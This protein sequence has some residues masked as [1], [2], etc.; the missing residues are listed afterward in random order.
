VWCGH[1]PQPLTH[2][3]C[4]GD[5]LVLAHLGRF[6]HAGCQ[7]KPE[8]AQQ[9]GQDGTDLHDAQGLVTHN[10]QS[11]RGVKTSETTNDNEAAGGVHADTAD[12]VS[13]SRK[14]SECDKPV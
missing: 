3:E 6:A 2:F 4:E 5:G 1:Q 13:G 10:T 7:L 8:A 11:E 14:V 12:V 9:G